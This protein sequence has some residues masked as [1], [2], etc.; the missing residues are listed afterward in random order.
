MNTRELPLWLQLPEPDPLMCSS[1]SAC[2]PQGC[3]ANLLCIYPV[4]V[5]VQLKNPQP[6]LI[7]AP[8]VLITTGN[9]VSTKVSKA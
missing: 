2:Q 5:Y 4:L 6:S 7:L 9:P 8:V 3:H 1:K